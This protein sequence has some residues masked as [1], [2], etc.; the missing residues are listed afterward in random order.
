MAVI[1]P[2]TPYLQGGHPLN[3]GLLGAWLFNEA[4]GGVSF[5]LPGRV[6]AAFSA[7][8]PAWA[9]GPRGPCLLFNG[10][11]TTI[12]DSS[13]T[14]T[15]GN[16]ISISFWTKSTASAAGSAFSIGPTNPR[17]QAHVPYSDNVLYWDYGDAGNGRIT[18]SF[19]AYVSVWAHVVLVNDGKASGSAFKAIYINGKLITSGSTNTADTSLLSTLQI[20]HYGASAVYHNGGLDDFRI[21][22]RVLS[23]TEILALYNT[24]Y[25]EFRPPSRV[26]A[27]DVGAAP[28]VV[29]PVLG[30]LTDR[31]ITGGRMAA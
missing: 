7:V 17:L 31:G 12:T 8:A 4:G 16:P 23:P 1:K 24:D 13:V 9:A 30:G 21:F 27:F 19:A 14:F 25:S 11:S 5:S 20:G 22:R 18:T 28:S 6:P 29:V 2:R 10:S 26:L 15:L 3:R